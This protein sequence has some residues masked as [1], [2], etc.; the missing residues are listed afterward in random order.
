MAQYCF[1]VVTDALPGREEEFNAWYDQ[2]HLADVL[3]IPGFVAAQRFKLAQA[4]GSLPGRYLALYEIETGDPEAAVAELTRRSGTKQMIIS[5]AMDMS[6]VSAMLF[7][8]I[9]A[10]RTAP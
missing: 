3:R 8:A 2:V 6:K 5:E 4:E 1:V 9:G 7:A 10:R